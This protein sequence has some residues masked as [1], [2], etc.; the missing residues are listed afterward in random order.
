VGFTHTDYL[1]KALNPEEL[2]KGIKTAKAR[3]KESRVEFDAIAVRGNSGVLFGSVLAYELKKPL[4]LVRKD[5]SHSMYNVEGELNAKTYLIVDD[6]TATG[7]TV[8][9]IIDEIEKFNH[10]VPV[11]LYQYKY[12][13][14]ELW[15]DEKDFRLSKFGYYRRRPR[16]EEFYPKGWSFKQHDEL[17][18]KASL[19]VAWY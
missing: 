4:I 5:S 2:R 13:E 16:L 6:F 19:P 12:P 7:N 15:L 3:I 8:R 9:T 10:A 1:R 17:R 11:G 18:A 14:Y